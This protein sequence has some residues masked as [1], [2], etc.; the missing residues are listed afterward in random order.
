MTVSSE[1]LSPPPTRVKDDYQVGAY[2]ALHH[3]IAP[4]PDVLQQEQAQ[5][6]FS[7]RAPAAPAFDSWGSALAKAS[8]TDRRQLIIIQYLVSGPHPVLPQIGDLLGNESFGE[9]EFE[10]QPQS[11]GTLR[12]GAAVR[13]FFSCCHCRRSCSRFRAAG[14]TRSSRTPPMPARARRADLAC[15]GGT[16]RERLFP[17]S[18]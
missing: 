17:S 4:V 1:K 16:Y 2:F 11:R 6:D 14:N 7:R 3:F 12:R 13:V 9:A 5:N 8:Y 15:S 10:Q 18:R